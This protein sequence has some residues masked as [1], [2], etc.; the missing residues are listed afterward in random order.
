[1]IT[2]LHE[3]TV[4][5]LIIYL[6]CLWW[7]RRH[8]SDPAWVNLVGFFGRHTGVAEALNW[9]A[10]AFVLLL[11]LD[12]GALLMRE[13]G[14]V[15]PGGLFAAARRCMSI[16]LVAQLQQ[17]FSAILALVFV[18]EL[19]RDLEL[20]L[21]L[22]VHTDLYGIIVGLMLALDTAQDFIWQTLDV[23][24]A[25]TL[26]ILGGALFVY[27]MT[28]CFVFVRLVNSIRAHVAESPNGTPRRR[29]F[30]KAYVVLA[31]FVPLTETLVSRAI[32]LWFIYS[33][34]RAA[35]AKW[36]SGVLRPYRKS[37]RARFVEN[38]QPKDYWLVDIRLAVGLSAILPHLIL[39]QGMISPDP[40]TISLYQYPVT[41]SFGLSIFII[42]FWFAVRLGM[43]GVGSFVTV[44]AAYAASYL[45]FPILWNDLFSLDGRFL[46]PQVVDKFVTIRLLGFGAGIGGLAACSLYVVWRWV[47]NRFIFRGGSWMGVECTALAASGMSVAA[48]SGV[49]LI[50]FAAV[51]HEWVVQL[52]YTTTPPIAMY[53]FMFF[54]VL[55][56]LVISEGLHKMW[57][58]SFKS[59]LL[60]WHKCRAESSAGDE[61][62]M[63]ET[64]P[65]VAESETHTKHVL[66]LQG[67]LS[68]TLVH[69]L[70]SLAI[71]GAVVAAFGL[72]VVTAN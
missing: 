48:L 65:W 36:L 13:F 72:L 57:L 66:G 17:F 64:W 10:M 30:S 58:W 52:R 19:H 15:D 31:L 38:L 23:F 41:I 67:F 8:S 63:M 47:S 9:L 56:V 5:W 42:V 49:S 7:A 25:T 68:F 12:E 27:A 51:S 37:H 33:R 1:M 14:V 53:P 16:P 26:V 45:A 32:F 61:Q 62:R 35:L 6:V 22:T 18:R 34:T 11:L 69:K 28:I 40:P 55:P 50:L 39:W 2:A 29:L 60:L 70:M 59:V 44:I 43:L 71:S 3:S 24:D 20:R 46:S 54:I 4:S 21:P